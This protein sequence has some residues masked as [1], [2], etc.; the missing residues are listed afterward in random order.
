M[1]PPL[2]RMILIFTALLAAS[3][4]TSRANQNRTYPVQDF[5]SVASLTK[6]RVR[7]YGRLLSTFTVVGRSEIQHQ[8]L[9][10]QANS[11]HR[12]PPACTTFL[13][14]LAGSRPRARSWKLRPAK[15]P[16]TK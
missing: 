10:I 2:T 6:L 12:W 16:V 5:S 14:H 8:M 7:R 4:A 9:T 11:M 3:Q 15:R 1:R 13:L